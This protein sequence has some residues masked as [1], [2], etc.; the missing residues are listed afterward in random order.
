MK[1]FLI[2]VGVLLIILAGHFGLTCLGFYNSFGK[3]DSLSIGT[4]FYSYLNA[5]EH[6]NGLALGLI[7]YFITY[8]V[9]KFRKTNTI[10]AVRVGVIT[11]VILL[12]GS[13]LAFGIHFSTPMYDFWKNKMGSFY[14]KV[15]LL[16]FFVF[17][18]FSVL[19]GSIIIWKNS[20]KFS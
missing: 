5:L 9:L 14:F 12:L 18:F 17:T 8:V 16:F 13:Y 20:K 2:Q 4:Y 15:Q 1:H 3:Y 7:G 11:M 6:F 10:K 19:I